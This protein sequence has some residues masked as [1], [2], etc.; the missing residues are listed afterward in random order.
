MSEQGEIQEWIAAAQR[1]DRLALAKLLAAYHPWFRK[2]VESRMN[3]AMK[4][5]LDPDD[6][7]QETYMDVARQIGE[8]EDHGPGSFVNWVHAILSQRLADALR[9]AH[10]QARDINREVPAAMGSGSSSYMNLLDQVYADPGTPSRVVRRDEAF[11]AL[12]GSLSELSEAHRQVIQLRFLE[13]LSVADVAAHLGKSEA[14][15]VALTKRALEALRQSMDR[16]GE[17]T[18]GV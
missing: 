2:Q 6:I 4:A 3:A 15:V 14:A 18:H 5:R 17:F 13:G 9:A 16:L 10:C 12:L 8:L 11:S 7:V 1:G